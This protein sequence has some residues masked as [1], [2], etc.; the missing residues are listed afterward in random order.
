MA[1]KY[2]IDAWQLLAFTSIQSEDVAS[3]VR[4][5][6]KLAANV[7]SLV[8]SPLA[9]G[10]ESGFSVVS[11]WTVASFVSYENVW[12]DPQI[13]LSPRPQNVTSSLEAAR[14]TTLRWADETAQLVW[15]KCNYVNRD[16][17][18]NPDRF[19]VNNSGN[20]RT[21]TDAVLYNS[22]AYALTKD[23][24][25][26]TR[27]ASFVRSW[28]LSTS[29]GM[30]PNMNY[31]QIHRGPGGQYGDSTGVLDLRH[32]CKV[33]V[34]LLILRQ[35]KASAWSSTDDNSFNK[36]ATQYIS[37]LTTSQNAIAAEN[38]LNNHG[39][40]YTT[41]LAA[42]QIAV[43]DTTGAHN[44][45][46]HY[47]ESPKGF[48]G[49]IAKNGDQPFE[50]GRTRPAHYRAFN[51]M[52]AVM[53]AQIGSY[54]GYNQGWTTKST[55]GGTISTALSFLL[56]TPANGNEDNDNS[57]LFMPTVAMIAST[58]NLPL[59]GKTRKGYAKRLRDVSHGTYDQEPWF[60]Y[61]QPLPNW[62][63]QV[64]EHN[65]AVLVLGP[66]LVTFGLSTIQ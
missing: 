15:E 21:M 36:W 65:L 20:F 25:Y 4:T 13:L 24:K 31:A 30:K 11:G 34:S 35:A 66:L 52:A 49:Q 45:I 18:V 29:K 57:P 1:L 48:V 39:S 16:G 19:A 37:W 64:M 59:S 62:G 22:M 63:S 14:N 7:H 54:V 50:S 47:F 2:T 8:P 10:Y 46:Q 40:F 61:E 53:N 44:T 33:V 55:Q 27:S 17:E 3:A 32:M 26:A 42:L 9:L 23:D 12:F 28:F 60:L 43:G 56:S 41:Q 51:L 38:S 5:W 58:S 6:V